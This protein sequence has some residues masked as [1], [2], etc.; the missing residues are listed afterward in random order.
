MASINIESFIITQQRDLL[1]LIIYNLKKADIIRLQET[2]S[3]LQNQTQWNCDW[4]GNILI[5]H[6]TNLSAGVAI[7]FFFVCL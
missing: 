1:C 2:H 5:S 4:K 6:G 3:D 7:L